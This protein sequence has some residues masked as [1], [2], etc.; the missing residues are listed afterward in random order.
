MSGFGGATAGIA[1]ASAIIG[2]IC[3]MGALLSMLGWLTT[4]MQTAATG[5]TPVEALSAIILIAAFAS[6]P[7]WLPTN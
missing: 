1:K 6:L 2:G 7:W 3:T 4:G 5:E